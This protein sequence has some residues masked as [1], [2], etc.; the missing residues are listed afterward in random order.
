MKKYSLIAIILC[1]YLLVKAQVQFSGSLLQANFEAFNLDLVSNNYPTV[2]DDAFTFSILFTNEENEDRV[3]NR[4][5]II[6]NH[7][8]KINNDAL[9]PNGGVNELS[10]RTIGVVSGTGYSIIEK[11]GI[12]FGPS[13]D[14]LI[15]QN[16]LQLL[17][18]LP[19]GLN[20]GNLLMNDVVAEDFRNTRFMF[21]GRL[22][23]N[24]N[25]KNKESN[26]SFGVGITGG[27]R[28]DPF[29]ENWRYQRSSV[30]VEIPGT[31][32]S[33]FLLGLSISIKGPKF[34]PPKPNKKQERS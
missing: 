9:T 29:K 4:N 17:R 7:F 33:G 16:R 23:L 5:G 30:K 8:E 28:W 27:Y 22:N 34:T 31:S 19:T 14:V 10:W 18:N 13:L 25:F 21:D 1:S 24:F 32:Q 20:F 2:E 26:S 12:T 6:F 3:T 15:V 11:K